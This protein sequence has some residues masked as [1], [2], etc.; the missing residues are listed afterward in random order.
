MCTIIEAAEMYAAKSISLSQLAEVIENFC[1]KYE[2]HLM[3]LALN[4]A[5]NY[6]DVLIMQKYSQDSIIHGLVKRS[7][8]RLESFINDYCK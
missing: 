4:Y 6:A 1:E 8:Q 3:R 2:I 7:R 5:N